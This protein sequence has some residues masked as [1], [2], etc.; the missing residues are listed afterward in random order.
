[1]RRL[2]AGAALMLIGCVLAASVSGAQT[3][4][5]TSTTS[6]TTTPSTTSTT[7]TDTDGPYLTLDQASPWGAP[8]GE[9]SATWT[10]AQE[11]PADAE[12]KY[13][14]HQPLSGSNPR[15]ALA[16]VLAGGSL[17]PSLQHE[18]DTPLV[19]LRTEGKATLTI[20][21]RSHS[22]SS[23]RLLVPN[24]GILPIGIDLV[25]T[26]GTVLQH[27]VLFLDRVPTAA[28]HPPLRVAARAEATTTPISRW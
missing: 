6:T 5:A 26:D 18:I 2:L 10:I 15:G 13:T 28:S 1:M 11:P 22:G 25:A 7:S 4:G 8:D 20:P 9:W 16:Q 3:P 24:A 17:G 27:S 14:I 12:V 19:Q 23:D 21:I